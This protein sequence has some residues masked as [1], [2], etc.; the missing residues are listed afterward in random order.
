MTEQRPFSEV[1]QDILRNLQEL[2]RA[3]LRLAK[4]EVRQDAGEAAAS[5][6]WM[7]AGLVIALTA[8]GFLLWS[9]AYGLA[10]VVP[11]WAA[12]LIMAVITGA[13]AMTLIM[14]GLRKFKRLRPMPERTIE[15]VKE[16]VEWIK[17]STR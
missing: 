9:A 7:A 3:E 17:Q 11:L 6:A 1:L 15:S 10:L 2:I 13:A 14:L 5:G 8:W 4:A 16:N 12:T